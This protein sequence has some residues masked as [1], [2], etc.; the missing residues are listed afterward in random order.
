MF[1]RVRRPSALE[2]H[3]WTRSGGEGEW[4]AIQ[5]AASDVQTAS[6]ICLATGQPWFSAPLGESISTLQDWNQSARRCAGLSEGRT[7]SSEESLR[8]LWFMPHRSRVLDGVG[9]AGLGQPVGLH[10]WQ[11][12]HTGWVTLPDILYMD[13][14]RK[15]THK[16]IKTSPLFEDF[17]FH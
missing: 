3:L 12:R 13:M 17:F 4:A 1:Q 5:K 15:N 8:R 7:L 14:F 11:N 16:S 10:W 2:K 6:L 9:V